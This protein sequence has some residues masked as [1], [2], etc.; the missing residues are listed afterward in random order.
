MLIKA[1]FRFP[2]IV[3]GI[4]FAVAVFA[5]GMVFSS[6]YYPNQPGQYP[7]QNTDAAPQNKETGSPPSIDSTN[8]GKSH[9]RQ[10]TK[11]EF[12]SAKLSDWALV[13]FT[14]FLVFFT[15]RLWVSTDKL[16]QTSINSDEQTRDLFSADQRPWINLSNPKIRISDDET[17]LMF[18]I[19]GIN[20][21]KTPAFAVEVRAKAHK[22]QIATPSVD[23]VKEFARTMKTTSGW[24]ESRRAIFP[25]TT[26]SLST[27]DEVEIAVGKR[28]DVVRVS[29]CVTYFANGDPKIYRTAGEVIFN[30][31][32]IDSADNIEG[33]WFSVSHFI[34]DIGV[35]YAD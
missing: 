14:G 31:K 17:R 5:M 27:F 11:S 32:H 18:E 8:A 16:W 23:L 30:V 15:Y 2:E 24:K 19:E 28:G 1:R 21:G 4:L 6:A 29:Y 25:N 34:N 33:D 26:A 35:T 10:E 7:T 12:W 22:S 3:F 13:A 9:E 20:I